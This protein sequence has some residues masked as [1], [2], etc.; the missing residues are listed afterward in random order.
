MTEKL[1]TAEQAQERLSE[2]EAMSD[3]TGEDR[4]AAEYAQTVVS[5]G[6]V[7]NAFRLTI[8]QQAEQIQRLQQVAVEAEVIF[9]EATGHDLTQQLERRGAKLERNDLE[10]MKP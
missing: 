8:E 7:I 6:V 3:W 9:W 4:I 5:Q 1:I 10:D 2:L